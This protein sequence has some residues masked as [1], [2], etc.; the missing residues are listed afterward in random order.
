MNKI[1][2]YLTKMNEIFSVEV[3]NLDF[4][5]FLSICSPIVMS[6]FNERRHMKEN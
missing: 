3:N 5:K 6:F 1:P 4:S 2:Q